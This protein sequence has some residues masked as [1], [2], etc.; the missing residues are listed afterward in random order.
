MEVPLAGATM[1]TDQARDYPA[2]A[3]ANIPVQVPLEGATVASAQAHPSV[4]PASYVPNM[5]VPLAGA[6][7]GTDQARDGPSVA[8]TSY[9]ANINGPLA[10]ATVSTAQASTPAAGYQAEPNNQFPEATSVDASPSAVAPLSGMTSPNSVA[11]TFAAVNSGIA[12]PNSM[13]TSSAI[14][15][16]RSSSPTST[17]RT[18]SPLAGK[19]GMQM[20]MPTAGMQMPAPAAGMHMAMSTDVHMGMATAA[21]RQ[22]QISSRESHRSAQS[23][24]RTSVVMA[25]GSATWHTSDIGGLQPEAA[26]LAVTGNA[27]RCACGHVFA[28][29]AI[30]CRQCGAMRPAVQGLGEI[31][32]EPYI[33]DVWEHSERHKLHSRNSIERELIDLGACRRSTS[34]SS[35]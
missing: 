5:Q 21:P 1:G 35:R 8:P 6:T 18:A 7:M 30:H 17:R 32:S 10:D 29:D 24:D 11:Y 4:A 31:H 15:T 20:A 2:V 23:Y 22:V 3:P 19:I 26:E 14:N 12:S 13:A 27:S 9:V 28:A 33:Q 16:Y 34:A 25:S